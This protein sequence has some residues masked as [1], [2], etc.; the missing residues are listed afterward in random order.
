LSV[1][2]AGR[3]VREG[4]AERHVGARFFAFYRRDYTFGESKMARH[5]DCVNFIGFGSESRS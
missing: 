2:R 4:L 5:L 1:A 3:P